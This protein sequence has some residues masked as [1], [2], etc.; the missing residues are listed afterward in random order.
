[1]QIAFSGQSAWQKKSQTKT[2]QN[3]EVVGGGNPARARDDSSNV[4]GARFEVERVLLTC[5][6]SAIHRGL[7]LNT[8]V[9]TVSSKQNESPDRKSHT[10]FKHGSQFQNSMAFPIDW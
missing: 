5:A 1:M 9:E 2:K 7:N 4:R 6:L 8:S 3:R 10:R